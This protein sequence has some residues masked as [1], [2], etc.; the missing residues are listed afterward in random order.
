VI[1]AVKRQISRKTGKEYARVTLEDFHGTAEAIVFPD[2]W[3]RLNQA[4]AVDAALL[5]TG[6]HSARDRSEDVAPFV[7]E[8]ARPLAE[9]EAAG[10]LG[11][12]VRWSAPRAP[13][14]S[15]ARA[16]ARVA[17]SHP[18]PA[19][20]YIDWSDGNGTTVRL[21]SRRLRVEPRDDTLR[22]L[23]ELFGGDAVSYVRAE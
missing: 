18:G 19:P 5:L 3:A 13:D 10:L 1:T 6:G 17:A 7:V 4:I 2:A 16:A 22:A 21:V 8:Q 23:R 9:L 15:M 11:V 12:A 14:A 20:L